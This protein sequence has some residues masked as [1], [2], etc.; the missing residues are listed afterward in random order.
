MPLG[1]FHFDGI[2]IESYSWLV[3]LMMTLQEFLIETAFNSSYIS[4]YPFL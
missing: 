4:F 1:Q 3:P 2:K